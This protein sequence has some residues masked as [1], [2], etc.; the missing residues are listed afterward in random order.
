MQDET[1]GS[2]EVGRGRANSSKIECIVGSQF[3]FLNVLLFSYGGRGSLEKWTQN[4]LEL[5]LSLENETGAGA[6][7]GFYF[8][9]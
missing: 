4:C 5:L 1:N 9:H 3:Y 2:G 6:G 7:R 8:L